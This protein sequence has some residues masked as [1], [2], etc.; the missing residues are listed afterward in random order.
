MT[1]KKIPQR[2]LEELKKIG[3]YTVENIK[4]L[5][6]DYPIQYLIGYTNFYGLDIIVNENV[7][8]PRYETE[9]LIEKLIKYINKYEI[10]N[11][12]ILDLCTG[13]GCIGLTLKHEI[14]TSKVTMTDISQKA[15]EVAKSNKDKL[16]LDVK[17]LISDLFEKIEEKDFNIIVSNPPYVKTT[18]ILPKNVTYEPSLALFSGE[19]GINHIKKIIESFNE[20]TTKKAII[21]LEINEESEKDITNIIIENKLN[22]TYK[23]EKDLCDKIRY[24]FIFK[25]CE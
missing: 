18:E 3:K 9:Y 22:I 11:P 16:N 15:L 17:L 10:E 25:N 8:I 24:L 14:P 5:E 7:L 13:S 4:K 12:K 21:A 2:E 23:Y 1:N 19:H 6:Q 20:Y